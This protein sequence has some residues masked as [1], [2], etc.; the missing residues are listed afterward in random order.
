MRTS[1]RILRKIDRWFSSPGWAY[2][3]M[4]HFHPMMPPRPPMRSRLED[5]LS[6]ELH[7]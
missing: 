5:Q 1:T 7:P 3:A 6:Q 4:W 2:S